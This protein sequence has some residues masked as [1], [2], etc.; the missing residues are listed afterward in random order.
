MPSQIYQIQTTPSQTF[1]DLQVIGY[2]DYI[3]S[4]KLYK[5]QLLSLHSALAKRLVPFTSIKGY[6][7]YF[8][9]MKD[10]TD[11]FKKNK[12]GSKYIIL[13]AGSYIYI[14]EFLGLILSLACLMRTN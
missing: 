4:D 3:L 5:V 1:A 13:M 7:S 12:N 10:V 6:F 9:I 8:L 2:D 14:R 11:F